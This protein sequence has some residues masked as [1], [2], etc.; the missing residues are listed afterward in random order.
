M[1]TLLL[2]V[3]VGCSREEAVVLEQQKVFDSRQ[4]VSAYAA[5]ADAV[6]KSQQRWSSAYALAVQSKDIDSIGTRVQKDVI[7]PLQTYIEQL[8]A[9]PT[10]DPMIEKH[11][12]AL[13]TAYDALLSDFQLFVKDLNSETYNENRRVLTTALA[14][15]HRAQSE[16]MKAMS[17]IYKD[18]GIRVTESDKA[19]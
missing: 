8:K 7:P 13:V 3:M 15:F 17:G 14:R 1:L 11:H 5:G 10:Q 9:I 6:R 2:I 16:Y 19:I 12:M 18:L 4:A